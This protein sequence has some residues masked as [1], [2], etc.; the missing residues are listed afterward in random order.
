MM[1]ATLSAKYACALLAF[2]TCSACGGALRQAQNGMAVV[3]SSAILPERHGKSKDFEYVTYSSSVGIFDYPKSDE[4]I[5]QIPNV[6]GGVCTNVLYGFGKKIIWIVGAADAITEYSVRT[7]K[8]IR[9]LSIPGSLGPPGGCAMDTSG[10]LAVTIVFGV[11]TSGGD[12]VIF[13]NATGSGTVLATP[14]VEEYFNGYDSEG[15]LF[16]DGFD[17]TSSFRLVELPKGGHTFKTIT[18]SNSVGFPGSLQWDGT[19]LTLLDQAANAMYRYTVRGTKATLKGTVSL[20]GAT[21]CAQTWIV[22]DFVMC[23]DEGNEAAE[24]FKYPAG[25]SVAA[26]LQGNSNAPIGTVAAQQ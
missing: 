26:V 19:Y 11:G 5:G 17:S 16:L 24:I 14:L 21:D 20:S 25:G 22:T 18:T 6:T 13:K 3:P 15:N 4:Q 1:N 2:A 12:V 10:D 9:T 7:K 8:A 23:A